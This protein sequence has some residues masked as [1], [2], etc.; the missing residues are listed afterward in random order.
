VCHCRHHVHGALGGTGIR[1]LARLNRDKAEYLKALAKA[2]C[3]LPFSAPTFN[4]FVVRFPDGFPTPGS[5]CWRKRSLPGCTWRPTTRNCPTALMCVTETS[6][7]ADMDAG[8]G[9]DIM[10]R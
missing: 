8:Q 3:T 7:K 9:G 1:E 5:A 2:G 10:K 4:E 6:S